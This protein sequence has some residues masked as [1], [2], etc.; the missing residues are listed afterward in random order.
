M[1]QPTTLTTTPIVD[2]ETN[3]DG[4]ITVVV[5]FGPDL[6]AN[7]TAAPWVA[8]VVNLTDLCR[9]VSLNLAAQVNANRKVGSVQ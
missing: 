5:D 1:T 4:T 9:L 8:G 2:T 6:R 7:F 3:D